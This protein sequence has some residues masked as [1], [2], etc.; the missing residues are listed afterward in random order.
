M[1]LFVRLGHLNGVAPRT[2]GCQ[3][4]VITFYVRYTAAPGAPYRVASYNLHGRED[5]GQDRS[6]HVEHREPG[7]SVDQAGSL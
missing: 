4:K 5:G 6:T 3:D 7:D 2:I 1:M